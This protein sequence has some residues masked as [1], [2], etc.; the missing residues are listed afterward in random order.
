MRCILSFLLLPFAG[1][2]NAQQ[3]N[4]FKIFAF[5]ITEYVVNAGDSIIVVQI[6]P[7]DGIEIPKDKMGLI[8]SV[9]TETDTSIILGQGRCSLIKGDYY[10][11]GIKQAKG[12]RLPKAGDLLYTFIQA[13]DLYEGLLYA[14]AK[15]SITLRKVREGDFYNMNDIL[16]MDEAKEKTLIDSLVADIHYTGK[17]MYIQNDK[18]DQVVKGGRFGG[19]KLFA[20]MEIITAKDV[21][22]FL[23]YVA[24]KPRIYGGDNWKISEI[25]ATWMISKTPTVIE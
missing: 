14:V 9:R 19:K 22:D 24:A 11:Y 2:T 13:P 17:A 16:W 21:A 8:R 15:H 5:P 7:G 3:G 10:Y 4:E 18:Q 25:F 20:T 1:I 23:K 12:S 6:I